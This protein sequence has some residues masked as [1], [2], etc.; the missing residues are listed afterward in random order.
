[1]IKKT[2][3]QPLINHKILSK[4]TWFFLIL[5]CILRG[6]VWLQQRSIFLDEANLI[7][8]YVEKSYTALFGH[9][10]YQ[11]YAPPLFSVV[12][13]FIFQIFDINELSA[14]LFPL[15]CGVA[16]LFVFY[17][18][19]RRLLSPFAALMA[20]LFVVFDKIFIDYSTECK[21]YAT[22]ALIAVL[23]L[24]LSQRIDFKSFNQ[25]KAL[26][27]AIVGSI[28]IWF[29]MPSIFVL[30]GVGAYYLHAFWENKDTKAMLQI[31]VVGT[32]WLVQF[33]VYFHFVLNTDAQSENLQDFHR[34]YFLAF[35]PLSIADLNL[36]ISQILGIIDRSIGITF[37]AAALSLIC[38]SL[39]IKQLWQNNRAVFLLL[40]LPIV[41]TLTASALHYYSLIAR[42]ILFFLPIFILLVFI[43]FD[44]VLQK[45]HWVFSILLTV[46]F[47][48][49]IIL[50]VQIL[51]PFQPFRNDYSELKEGLEFIKKEK[52]PDEV[53]FT[54]HGVT[55]VMRYYTQH[56]DRPYTF[57]KLIMQDYVCCD[58]N[59][60]ENALIELHK[61]EEKRIW[62]LGDQPTHDNFLRFIES[63]NGRIL[64]KYEF[65]RGVALLYEVK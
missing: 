60:F 35:P 64:K 56:C 4:I 34:A 23:L 49:T 1:M 61:K 55:P 22:D 54:A 25:K 50:Q 8:N 44:Y 30:A 32:F 58:P 33:A 15:L 5:G 40:V 65:H 41:L 45:T 59:L 11:Q 43:G 51:K 36:F 52:Q 48:S 47:I 9:L 7:R 20:V 62:L 26:L 29:S 63:Q 42:L 24:L 10:D 39:G 27:W 21:Q 28:A 6:A 31:A 14:K 53:L 16:M 13:K 12:M 57:D 3:I 18:L 37:L 2:D 17:A 38:F 19:S 46:A